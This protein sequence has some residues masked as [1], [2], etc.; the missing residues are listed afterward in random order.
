MYSWSC[1]VC[2]SLFC[3]FNRRPI[4]TGW[5]AALLRA[6]VPPEVLQ[7]PHH[8]PQVN[9]SPFFFGHK[10]DIELWKI[11]NGFE[12]YIEKDLLN[13]ALV[14]A[15]VSQYFPIP[16]KRGPPAQNPFTAAKKKAK[17]TQSANVL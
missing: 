4:K 14:E 17:H 3:P 6:R 9:W 15:I 10:L 1:N 8:S 7:Q 2:N 12:K 5:D 16:K 11:E 13:Q